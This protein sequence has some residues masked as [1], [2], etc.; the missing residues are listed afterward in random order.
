MSGHKQRKW[1]LM[2]MHE[3]ADRSTCLINA[4]QR[5]TYGAIIFMDIDCLDFVQIVKDLRGV[6]T[7]VKA[8]KRQKSTGGR[9]TSRKKRS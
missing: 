9:K 3:N 5:E 6:V 2:T 4:T 7:K 1:R 8:M